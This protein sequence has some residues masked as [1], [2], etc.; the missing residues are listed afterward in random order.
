MFQMQFPMQF[1]MLLLYVCLKEVNYKWLNN[2]D[3]WGKMGGGT[4]LLILIPRGMDIRKR[5]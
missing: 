3:W 4:R 1:P 2:A 5:N